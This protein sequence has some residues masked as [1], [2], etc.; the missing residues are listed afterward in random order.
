[1]TVLETTKISD[2]EWTIMQVLWSKGPASSQ[3]IVALIQQKKTWAPTTIK[4]LISRLIQKGFIHSEKQ[5]KKPIYHPTVS[6]KASMISA[7]ENLFMHICSKK[8]GITISQ[9]I[10][11]ATLSHEDVALLEQ[12]ITEKR[13]HAVDS[14]ACNCVIGLCECAEHQP[15]QHCH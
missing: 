15:E 5:G 13:K 12:V 6:E 10:Q 8:I 11:Q 7:S 4:T 3:E 9:L 14:I 2:S 1:M